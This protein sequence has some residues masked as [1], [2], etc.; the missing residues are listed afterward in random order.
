ML[1]AFGAT[2][3]TF[4]MVTYALEPAIPGSSSRLPAAACSPAPT[5]S[6]G[7]GLAVR[8]C[9]GD[10]D[11]RSGSTLLSRAGVSTAETL[12]LGAL[13]VPLEL[14]TFAVAVA[15]GL[16]GLP[17]EKRMHAQLRV[18][19]LWNRCSSSSGADQSISPSRPG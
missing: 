4:M 14:D 12:R 19:R 17:R 16:A 11:G 7:G 2:A 9:R 8:C 5:V 13:V 1:T 10:L 3:I 15:L 18:C 6:L